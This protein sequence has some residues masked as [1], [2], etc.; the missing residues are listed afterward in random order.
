MMSCLDLIPIMRHKDVVAKHKSHIN[1][2]SG[3]K[4]LKSMIMA[5]IISGMLYA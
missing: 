4:A 1:M 5:L 2:I 3:K